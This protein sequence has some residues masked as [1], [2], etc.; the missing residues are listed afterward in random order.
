MSKFAQGCSSPVPR[1]C[2]VVVS[3]NQSHDNA[4]I[5]SIL[6]ALFKAGLYER[7]GELFDH[8]GRVEDALNTYRKGNAYR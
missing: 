4:I 7:A 6:A 2:Q 5:E 3:K 1:V 8:L